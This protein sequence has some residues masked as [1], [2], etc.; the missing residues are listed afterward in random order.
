MGSVKLYG[1]LGITQQTA[2]LLTRR[3]RKS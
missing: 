1:E 2:W 3:N